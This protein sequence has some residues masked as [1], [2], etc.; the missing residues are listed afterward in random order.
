M[1]GSSAPADFCVVTVVQ[2]RVSAPSLGLSS[3]AAAAASAAPVVPPDG[4]G[5]LVL[6]PPPR[7]GAEHAP[8]L[9]GLSLVRLRQ[10]C[11]LLHTTGC[12]PNWQ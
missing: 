10:L 3:L 2:P 6:A 7:A 9:A 8:L 12:R 4:A 1:T 11:C 5:S